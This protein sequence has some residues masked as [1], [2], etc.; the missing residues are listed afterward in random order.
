[1][2]PSADQQWLANVMREHGWSQSELAR[3][4]GIHPAAINRVA[5]GKRST[6]GRLA[7]AGIERAIAEAGQPFR[8]ADV[9]PAKASRDLRCNVCALAA[10][11]AARDADPSLLWVAGRVEECIARLEAEIGR[12]GR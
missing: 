11:Y 7:K 12:P 4:A 1:M 8:I 9:T 6:L 3:R 2:I 10:L 5:V